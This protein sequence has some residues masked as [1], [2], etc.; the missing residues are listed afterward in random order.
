MARSSI[1]NR[2][3]WQFLLQE[4][5]AVTLLVGLAAGICRQG[6]QAAAAL[7]VAA[8]PLSGPGLMLWGS[9][10]EHRWLETLGAGF[11]LCVPILLFAA[12]LLPAHLGG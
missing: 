4:L 6:P 8:I 3:H 10:F 7:A 12:A 1:V 9:I 11:T 2:R 5:L